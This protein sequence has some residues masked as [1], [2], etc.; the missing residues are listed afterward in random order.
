MNLHPSQ[1]LIL[2]VLALPL[3]ASNASAA[4]LPAGS[5]AILSGTSSLLDTLPSPVGRSRTSADAVSRDGA[6]VAFSSGSDGLAAGDDDSVENV[7]VKNRATGDVVLVS[8]STGAS[9]DPAHDD[10]DSAAVSDDGTRVA[11]VC[12]GPLDAAD[13][14]GQDDVYVRDLPSGTTLLVSRA[15]SDGA[16]GDSLSFD[17]A[18]SADGR[19]VAFASL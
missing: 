13:T 15:D 18:L 12:E 8:R 5:T 10:C 16:V 17:P 6:I 14:N 4:S 1:L 3:G 7:Y 9:G 2:A 11:F 19:F